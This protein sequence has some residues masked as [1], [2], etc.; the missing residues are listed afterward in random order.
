MRFLR[1]IINYFR[2][3][4]PLPSPSPLPKRPVIALV[5]GHSLVAQGAI[6][7][8]GITEFQKW[9]ETAQRVYENINNK[10]ICVTA[11]RNGT[12]IRG[13]IDRAV[14]QGADIIIELHFNFFDGEAHGA[15]ILVRFPCDLAQSFLDQWCS[16]AKLRNRGVKVVSRNQPG[17]ASVDQIELRGRKGF[18]FEAFF[19]DNPSDYRDMDTVVNFLTNWIIKTH[20]GK[21]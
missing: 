4:Q 8:N 10:N 11:D 2:R 3:P 6:A 7:H 17:F 19:G 9:S 15:E 13:A 16:Y 5:P 21:L 1:A 12:N 14:D 18:L 20:E